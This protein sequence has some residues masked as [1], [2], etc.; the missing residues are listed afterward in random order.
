MPRLTIVLDVDDVDPRLEDPHD[1]ARE[2]LLQPTEG[3]GRDFAIQDYAGNT[4]DFVSAEW[5]TPA[6][7]AVGLSLP[8]EE[9]AVGLMGVYRVGWEAFDAWDELL[10]GHASRQRVMA[11]MTPLMASFHHALE[12]FDRVTEVV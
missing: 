8:P 10:Q 4:V 7:K 3:W 11:V 2:V 9:T 5:D 6:P 1:V 12:A